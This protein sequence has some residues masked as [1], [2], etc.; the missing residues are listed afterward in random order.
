MTKNHKFLEEVQAEFD[1]DDEI[2][3]VRIKCLSWN[4]SH[5]E[6]AILFLD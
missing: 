6:V 2:V 5:L 3:V 4:I 1:K